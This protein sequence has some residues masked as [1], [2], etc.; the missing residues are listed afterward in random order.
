MYGAQEGGYR[1]GARADRKRAAKARGRSALTRKGGDQ[2]AAVLQAD[3]DFQANLR[4]ARTEENALA[5]I[6]GPTGHTHAVKLAKEHGTFT[7]DDVT[8][9]LE[10]GWQVLPAATVPAKL[11]ATLGPLEPAH[12]S[13]NPSALDP[14]RVLGPKLE[15]RAVVLAHPQPVIGADLIHQFREAGYDVSPA[16]KA[17]REGLRVKAS[18]NPSGKVRH[19]SETGRAKE[20]NASSMAKQSSKPPRKTPKAKAKPAASKT[21]AKATSKRKATPKAPAAPKAPAKV[22]PLRS[23]AADTHRLLKTIEKAAKAHAP[24]KPTKGKAPRLQVEKVTVVAKA[25]NPTTANRLQKAWYTWTGAKP[26]QV[27]LVKVQA[28][29]VSTPAGPVHLPS[30]VVFLGRLTKLITKRGEVRDFGASGPYL[31]SNADLE[32]LW[33]LS[34]K[35]HRFHLKELSLIGY[36]AKKH[37]FGDREPV[38]Y[39]HAFEGPTQAA[40]VGQVGRIK[41]SFHLTPRGIEG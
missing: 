18:P 29:T 14:A 35:A 16:P 26:G 13:V 22:Q 38:E 4:A 3:K 24:K 6:L 11:G 15:A 2:L 34:P 41:G 23:R 19:G 33:F 10:A 1:S 7:T 12:L 36:L 39:I 21:K 8:A 28:A 5:R 37:K 40:M 30:E 9:F 20:R 31:V 27:H 17:A 25:I 32:H